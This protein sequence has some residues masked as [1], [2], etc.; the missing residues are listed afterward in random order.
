MRRPSLRQYLDLRSAKTQGKREMSLL[1]LAWGKVKLW[2][3]TRCPW[4]AEGIRGRKNEENAHTLEVT[5]ALFRAVYA[6]ADQVLR[7]G[8][9][10]QAARPQQCGP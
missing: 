6:Q 4:P 3:M 1:R 5:P 7:D 10:I 8:M 9:G 2:S